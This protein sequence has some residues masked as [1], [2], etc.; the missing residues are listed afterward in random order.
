[1]SE[2][3]RSIAVAEHCDE[4]GFDALPT[5]SQR[6]APAVRTIGAAFRMRLTDPRADVMS[7]P[8]PDTWSPL[9]YGA[10]I[11][12]VVAIWSWAMKLA[13]TG[14]RPQFPAP[15]PD[16]ADTAAE[17]GGYGT[18]DPRAVA[19]EILANTDRMARKF[20]TV[21]GEDWERVI[22]LGDEELTVLDIANKILHEGHHHLQ[23]IDRQGAS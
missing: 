2:P 18:L 1:M 16:V 9:E 10:H 3:S 12:D 6:I 15:D 22:V 23:D 19:E 5:G 13:L 14:H 8:D 21:D 20:E 11:R 17:A 7:R 4:C